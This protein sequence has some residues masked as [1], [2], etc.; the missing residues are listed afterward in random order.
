MEL[1]LCRETV[2]C[3]ETVRHT[4][5]YQEETQEAIVPDACPDILRIL[6]TRGQ[7]FLTGKQVRD[8][9]VSVTG[10]VRASVFYLPE[11]PERAPRR[12]EIT[13][14]FTCQSEAP[15]LKSQG[16]VL[17]SP[18]LRW[19]QARTLNPRKVLLRVD[20]AVDLSAYQPDVIQLCCGV[21]ADESYG[22][23]QLVTQESTYVT[24]AVLEKPFTFSDRWDMG[25]VG[26]ETC[27]VLS[28]VGEPVCS[29][30]KLIGSKLI[31][32]GEVALETLVCTGGEL[33]TVRQSMV[34]SQIMEVPEAGEDSCC[35][36]RV[37]LTELTASVTDEEIT[38]ELLAQAVVR[39]QRTLPVLKDLYSTGWEAETSSQTYPMYHVL[40][41]GVKTA[42]VRELIETTTLVRTAVHCWAELGEIRLS[43]EREQAEFLAEVHLNLIYLDDGDQLQSVHKVLSV[44]CPAERGGECAQCWCT[45]PRELFVA[46]AA[47]GLEVRF[48][49]EFHCLSLVQRQMTG[50]ISAALTGE[51]QRGSGTQPSVVLRLAAPGECLWDI[52]KAYATTAEQIAQ[53]NE[54][55]NDA[56]PAGKMLLIP[57]VR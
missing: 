7:A 33:R 32:K 41:D 57:R 35:Q 5:V 10:F 2:S 30:C 38:L 55:E 27:D 51:R 11:E 28:V 20:L 19:A 43:R 6:D 39:E 54:L 53:A 17:A 8:G 3:F 40:E 25:G 16:I 34:F 14:P 44:A 31:L 23:Q 37:A 26:Q 50:I 1:E 24:A 42:S 9:M 47:G 49:M 45:G 46:P 56:L 21:N 36:V 4:T 13:L 48:S 29:E 18:R 12:L 52:A 15:G 22:I